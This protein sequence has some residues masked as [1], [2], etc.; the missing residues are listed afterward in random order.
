MSKTVRM[1]PDES[2]M[3]LVDNTTGA[4]GN[5]QGVVLIDP[6]TGLPT[7]AASVYIESTEYVAAHNFTGATAGD[8]IVRINQ[9]DISVSPATLTSTAWYNVTTGL[10]LASPPTG[11][12]LIYAGAT[13][14]T[15]AELR[16]SAV[17]VSLPTTPTANL[18]TIAAQTTLTAAQLPAVLGNQAGVTS[19]GVALSTEDKALLPASIGSKAAASSFA[20]TLSTENVALLPASIGKKADAAS[21]AVTLSTED[22]TALTDVGTK[23]DAIKADLDTIVIQTDGYTPANIAGAASTLVKSGAGLVHAVTINTGGSG[24]STVKLYDGTDA[25]GT[26]FATIDSKTPATSLEYHANFT[27][28]LFVATVGAPDITVLYR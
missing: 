11:T 26:L 23:L 8:E 4:I 24:S 14:L 3:Q 18:A 13:G 22:Y 5:L 6:G 16:A 12:N 7:G 1:S 20:V 19:L 21:F 28:G 17:P 27:V 25:F 15:D 9:W 2:M 10:A